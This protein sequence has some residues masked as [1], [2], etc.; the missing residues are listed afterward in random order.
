M[1]GTFDCLACFLL[2]S[3]LHVCVCFPCVC[4]DDNYTYYFKLYLDQVTPYE[5]INADT[6]AEGT[7]SKHWARDVLVVRLQTY[8]AARGFLPNALNRPAGSWPIA[9]TL[10]NAADG[11]FYDAHAPPR[12]VLD[13]QAKLEM[14]CTLGDTSGQVHC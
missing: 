3:S 11:F 2:I 7:I 4:F 10:P 8:L 6:Y 9:R 14:G 12:R 1:H 13:V 5:R